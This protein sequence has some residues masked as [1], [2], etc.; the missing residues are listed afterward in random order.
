LSFLVSWPALGRAARLV[1]EHRAD[2]DGAHYEILTRAVDV[3]RAKHALAATLVLRAMIDFT[4]G[5]SRASRYK[6][7]ARHLR[8]CAGLSLAIADFQGH[9]THEA[10]EARLRREHGRKPAFWGLVG[11]ERT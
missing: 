9:E 10:Y 7:A 8:D 5:K 4:L 1:I 6:H 3:L 2:L 11:R